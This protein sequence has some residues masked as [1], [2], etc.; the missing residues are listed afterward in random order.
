[1]L[2]FRDD[3]FR[4]QVEE[5]CGVRPTWS[6]ETFGDVDEDVRRSVA[7][8]RSSPFIPRTD[9]VRGFVYEVETGRLREV[10]AQER[11][12]G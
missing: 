1:M 11:A 10:P 5:D 2:T 6:A 7:R 8:I 3:D 9:Q 12:R 4:R